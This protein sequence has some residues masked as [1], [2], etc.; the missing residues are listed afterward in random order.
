MWSLLCCATRPLRLLITSHCQRPRP[1]DVENSAL[2]TALFTIGMCRPTAAVDP[3]IYSATLVSCLTLHN[4][5]VK[6]VRR[7]I[8]GCAVLGNRLNVKSH[9]N[10]HQHQRMTKVRADKELIAV[11]S[12]RLK[13]S[14]SAFYPLDPQKKIRS[15]RPHFTRCSICRSA[16]PQIRILPEAAEMTFVCKYHTV[17]SR[18][19]W[20]CGTTVVL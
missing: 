3:V 20:Y 5:A 12:G 13:K 1:F 2:L 16:F 8:F 14:A 17:V 7:S 11:C 18:Y 10:H 6:L 19:L 15:Y 9:H 4:T